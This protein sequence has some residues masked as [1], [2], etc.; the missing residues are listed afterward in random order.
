M[1]IDKLSLKNFRKEFEDSFFEKAYEK[2]ILN[3]I[4][5]DNEILN[6]LENAIIFLNFGDLDLQKLGYK[7][8][9]NYSNQYNDFEPLYDFAINKGYM[10][11][12]KI[13]EKKY[14]DS[15]YIQEHFYNLY[16]TAYQENF[17]D[18]EIYIS[19]GQK[20]L[21]EFSNANS[22]FVLSA[23]TSYGKSEIIVSKVFSNLGKKICIIVPSKALLAQTKRR[24]LEKVIN[25]NLQ[26]IITNPEMYNDNDDNFVAVLTQER[27]FRLL[28]KNNEL[29]LDLV[30][31][32]EAH[33]LFGNKDKDGDKRAILLAQTIMILKKRNENVILNF[34]SPFISNSEN[35]RIKYSNYS[36]VSE[37]TK[38][39]IK[40][41]KYFICETGNLEIYDQ[42]TNEFINTNR[43][44]ENPIDLIQNEKS[45][46]NIIYLNRP[47]NIE[48]FAKNLANVN[49]SNDMQVDEIIE[50]ISDFIHP[51]YNL[52]DYIKKGI[53]YHHG[54][55]PEVIRL[56]VENI[57]SNT[58]KLEYII[59]S[60]T[61]LEGVN[62]PAEK[63]FLL[64]LSKGKGYLSKSHF[65]NLIGRVNR[66][67]EIFSNESGNLN[68]LE[69]HIYVVKSEYMAEN[70]NLTKFIED[71]AKT[72]LEIN[73]EVN[74]ILLKDESSLNKK[75]KED[76]LNTLEY[77]E[78]IEPNSTSLE[79]VVYVES[80]IAKLCYQNNI[81]DFNIKD[82]EKQLNI[83][84]ENYMQKNNSLI[85]N[86]NQ[87]TETIY[88]IFIS[89]INITNDNISRLNNVSARSFYSM[90]I[91][92]RS[93]SASFKEM[94]N[95]FIRYWSKLEGDNLKIFVGG[96]WG[97][98]PSRFS[99]W[100]LLYVD[101]S[102][103]NDQ[104]KINLAIVK[105][106]EEQEFI[107]FNLQKYIDIIY[108]LNLINSDFYDRVK[109]GS[110]N[111]K[112][113]TLLKNGFSLELAKCITKVEYSDYINI[114]TE[115]D[116][117]IIKKSIVEVMKTNN[118]NKIL[119]FEI[120]YHINS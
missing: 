103:K 37:N 73:D 77:L 22:N 89:E 16:N 104:E 18:K 23:P 113:I 105:I 11:I 87:L 108:E 120:Q 2:L 68:L 48:E 46:K 53:V 42:F 94:I 13:I 115:T 111:K 29:K 67:S 65:K 91:E 107:E 93:R 83:N 9:V 60:S 63:I 88:A 43:N 56:Y 1:E 44:Y 66:F 40:T 81:Y 78:N 28:Q 52:I 96:K 24:L 6:L 27:L 71:R 70:A 15:T 10:P 95:S 75:E 47:Q 76:L 4:L 58:K 61:L 54:G 8:I 74:N 33:N 21:I 80:E 90:L 109:Y 7:I 49:N 12:S 84:L 62:I 97:E 110:S 102:K 64:S 45:S 51:K 34:F 55:M 3:V 14:L 57:F 30:L 32:D 117:L 106:T 69:P 39:F 99:G 36:L 100:K 98:E 17:K 38:E 85:E 50:T 101:L 41:E 92:W 86:S 112:T 59:T 114:N 25:N 118:E 119:V 116:N 20:K 79:N 82:S 35:L 26:R 31:I 5:E 19:S 72:E